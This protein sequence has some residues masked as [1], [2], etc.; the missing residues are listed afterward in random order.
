MSTIV[1]LSAFMMP[2]FTAISLMF[3]MLLPLNATL[4]RYFWQMLMICWMRLTL[5]A[6]VAMM[7]R[8]SALL[9]TMRSIVSPTLRSDIVK[10]SR[11]MLVDSPSIS[12]TPSSPICA[13]RGRSMLSPSIGV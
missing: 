4:R 5:D 10:P 13:S 12:L 9:S 7:I 8:L 1:P 3:F 6:N 11:S 2:S